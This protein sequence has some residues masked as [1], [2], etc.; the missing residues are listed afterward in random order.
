MIVLASAHQ[1]S[2]A[3]PELFFK[4]WVDHATWP[5]WSPDTEWVR[6]DG[7][8]LTGARGVLKPR[9]GPKTKFEIVEFEEDSVYTDVSVL[10]GASLTFRHTVAPTNAGSELTV[11][12]WLDGRLGWFWARTACTGFA[13]S[14]PAD[15]DR[16]VAVVESR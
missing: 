11:Q 3:T 10:P 15:L 4:R 6:V 1:T 16:L 12:V 9:G 13:T 2:T 7:P 14:V 8:V 5:E